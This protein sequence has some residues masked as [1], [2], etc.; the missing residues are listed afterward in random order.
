MYNNIY[1]KYYSVDRLQVYTLH[2]TDINLNS[3][4]MYNNFG[5][6]NV[7]FIIMHVY[8]EN[9]IIILVPICIYY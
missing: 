7:Y 1:T 4:L 9:I 5:L 6:K 3:I 2:H 8:V